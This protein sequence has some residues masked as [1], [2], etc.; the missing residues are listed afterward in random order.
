MLVQT[1]NKTKKKKKKK[2]K[3]DLYIILVTAYVG[4]VHG[5]ARMTR[6]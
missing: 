5:L 1:K 6:Q 3:I 4:N 2:K